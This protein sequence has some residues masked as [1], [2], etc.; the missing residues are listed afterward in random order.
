MIC[1][2]F[3]KESYMSKNTFFKISI[4]FCL[5][6]AVVYGIGRIYYYTT[7][8]FTTSN[9][10]STLEFDERFETK[11]ISD[12]DKN[13]IDS[14]LSQKFSYLGKGCQ[15]Y[16][17]AS[18]DGQYVIKFFKY[19]R[20]TPQ[21]WHNL[22]AFIPAFNEHRLMKIE[23]KKLE[24]ES[25]FSS[26]KL[27][28]DE[29]RQET[30]LVFVHLNKSKDLNKKLVIF[31]KL[32]FEHHLNLDDFEFLIQ[33]RAHMLEAT[34]HQQMK[35][36]KADMAKRLLDDLFDTLVAEYQKGFGDNDHALLQNTGVIDGKAVHIDVGQ[37]V[38]NENLKNMDIL[39]QEIFNKT[40]RLRLWLNQQYPELSEH[41][42]QRL[43]AFIGPKFNELKPTLKDMGIE[44]F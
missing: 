16:V 13:L 5:T 4:W 1:I 18:E 15:S 11:R 27:A 26:C 33:K 7:D 43:H 3:S 25:I 34:L 44:E 28:F 20:L 40:Y 29:L 21:K 32:N 39:T 30:G 31:D 8:G 17:F 6:I 10:A 42:D 14:V 9:I 24:L 38:Q 19:Q 37:F 2:I 36:N 23:Q 12:E 22:F 41:L 35:A